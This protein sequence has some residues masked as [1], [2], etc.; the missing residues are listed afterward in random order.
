MGQERM[1]REKIKKLP[2]R[3]NVS[4]IV[5][6]QK[7]FLL[8]QLAGW[9][10]NWWKFPQGGM[11]ENESEESAARRELFE[12]LGSENFRIVAKSSH[13]HQYDWPEDSI[14][15]AGYRWRGQ[16][17]RFLLVEHLGTD[18]EIQINRDEVQQYKWTELK[19]LFKNIDHDNPLF[20]NYKNVIEK[21]LLE[22]GML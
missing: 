5:F 20:V 6:R 11:E 19:D 16:S 12:E 22:F 8:V 2:Y 1:T 13:I 14:K 18:E 7:R 17:L 3:N 10:D 9:P 21:V 4:C 15:K